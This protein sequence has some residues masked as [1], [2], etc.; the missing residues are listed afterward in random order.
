MKNEEMDVKKERTAKG[1]SGVEIKRKQ[2]T[3]LFLALA[4]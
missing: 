4:S 1:E 2:G 3:S